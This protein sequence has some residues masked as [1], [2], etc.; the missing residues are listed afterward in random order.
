MTSKFIIPGINISLNEHLAKR[1]GV[2]D[3]E[4]VALKVSHQLKFMIFS[5]A[6]QYKKDPKVLQML[7]AVETALEFEQQKLWHFE[8]NKRFH[9]FFEFPGCTCPK[10]DNI[11]R[12]GVGPFIFYTSCPVHGDS[13]SE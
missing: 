6:Q 8:P 9:R 12:I 5:A 10:L 3:D 4:L 13:T 11:D 1:Q 7:Y 2:T